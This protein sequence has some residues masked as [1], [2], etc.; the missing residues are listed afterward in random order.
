MDG[1]DA[2][3]EKAVALLKDGAN[4]MIRPSLPEA[5]NEIAARDLGDAMNMLYG[6][7][8]LF[9]AENEGR[10]TMVMDIFYKDVGGIFVSKLA[11]D[12]Q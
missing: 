5:S 3:A 11:M 9:D 1:A 10:A 12:I 2:L 8:E 4:L 7:T 6:G